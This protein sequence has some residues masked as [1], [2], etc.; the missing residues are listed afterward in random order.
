MKRIG[1]TF[2]LLT[3]GDGEHRELHQVPAHP[4]Q[5]GGVLHGADDVPVD[6]VPE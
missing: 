5:Q 4:L 6:L 2:A 1:V 3:G